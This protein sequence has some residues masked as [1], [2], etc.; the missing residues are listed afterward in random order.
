MSLPIGDLLKSIATMTEKKGKERTGFNNPDIPEMK[1]PP[2]RRN[3]RVQ[4]RFYRDMRAN[5]QPRSV[6]NLSIAS[7]GLLPGLKPSRQ[8]FMLE[9]AID[10]ANI[11]AMHDPIT[12]LPNNYQEGNIGFQYQLR[13]SQ[14][15][16]SNSVGLVQKAR[17]SWYNRVNMFAIPAE[18]VRPVR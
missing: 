14:Q 1:R 10:P 5:N 6:A 17:R 8:A 2:K 7:S 18:P 13:P 9:G 15:T 16:E 12:S 4:D 11:R 3:P